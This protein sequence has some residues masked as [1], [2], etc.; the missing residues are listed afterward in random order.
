M[1]LAVF[2]CL[3][4]GVQWQ[5]PAGFISSGTIA[6]LED[7]AA[8]QDWARGVLDGQRRG[9]EVWAGASRERLR[10]VFPKRR[11]NVYHNFSCPDC[12]V[13]LKF[14]PLNP[15]RFRC[16]SCNRD[17]DP[18]TDAGI[19][20]KGDRYNGT[21]YDGWACLFFQ[22]ASNAALN[23]ALI[24]RLDACGDW[25]GRGREL[26]LLFADTIKNMPTVQPGEG[27]SARIFTYAREGESVICYELAQAYELLR[28]TMTPEERAHVEQ[29]LFKRML[30][31]VM[32]QPAYTFDHNNVYQFHR[33]V[34][35]T[36][37]ALEREDL[38]DWCFGYGDYSPE[39][40]PDHRSLRRIVA[41][42]FKPDGA[43]WEMCSGYHLYPM[44]AFCELAVV[45]HH[46]S[47]MAPARFP[48]EQYDLTSPAN[49]GGKVIK[50][51]LE[52][53]VSMAMPDRTMA[54]VGDSPAPRSGMD[55]YAMTAEVGYRYFDVCAVGDYEALRQGKRSWAGFLAGAPRIVQRPTAFT[56]SYLSS[57]WVSL[58]NEWNGNR[59]WAGLNA[60]I[61]GGGH[62][63]ADRLT[64]TLFSQGKLLALE[65]GTPYNEQVTR[66]LGTLS[67]AH[68]TVTVDRV[69]QKQG[70]AL[71]GAEIPETALFFCA[72][73]VQFA[74]VRAD[75]LYPQTQV[76][77]RSVALIEDIVIDVFRV[78]GGATHDWIVNHA[79]PPP[80]LSVT[81]EPA[82]F[83]PVDW[84][85]NGGSRILRATSDDAWQAQWAVEDVTSRLTLCG[86]NATEIYAIETYPIDSA[87]VTSEHPPC[88]TLCVRRGDDAPFIA[89]WDA[90]RETPNL[91]SC[92]QLAGR[93]ALVLR[94]KSNTYDILIGPGTVQFPDG[95]TL[96]SDASF[97]VVKNATAAACAGGTYLEA[98]TPQG[99]VRLDLNQNANAWADWSR[100][101]VQSAAVPCIQYDTFAGADHPRENSVALTFAKR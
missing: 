47:E 49:P 41:T 93:D 11:G 42:H 14:E 21:M 37:I 5:H 72:P 56:S 63:H 19:Y 53:F 50:S 83:E 85:A 17:F 38:I 73:F 12:R 95:V 9:F 99:T 39:K 25:L 100:E 34:L 76:Y 84:L 82:A 40:L 55:A 65:K 36:A 77:R 62:Q 29:D 33:T 74:E 52:W 61:P 92:V 7:R 71:T 75:H 20:P 91:E 98:V 26:L 48:A 88:Q 101:D 3:V 18:E 8:T 27:D 16:A 45:S 70:E 90:W 51:A 67:P 66:I 15:D 94:T 68:N 22:T 87:V 97:C 31:D 80:T 89:V 60:L 57:G 28:D 79:G 6:E 35:Q 43:F 24:G 78:S 46:L 13:R 2:F 23:L 30:D 58:R 86:A 4:A 1:A 64:L 10:A 69:S 44:N 81:A 59:V 54:V 96:D 32:W